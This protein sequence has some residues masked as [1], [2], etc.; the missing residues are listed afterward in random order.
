MI[1]KNKIP[2]TNVEFSIGGDTFYYTLKY[3]HFSKDSY[4]N[5]YI[6]LILEAR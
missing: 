5:Y 3:H 4:N 2:D 6:D 1:D